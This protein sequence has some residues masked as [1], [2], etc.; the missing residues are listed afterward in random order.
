MTSDYN[1]CKC[2]PRAWIVFPIEL[3]RPRP[4]FLRQP[5]AN[6]NFTAMHHLVLAL[7]I[8]P[9]HL[10][11]LEDGDSDYHSSQETNNS[12]PC[13]DRPFSRRRTHHPTD[14]I[15]F[16]PSPALWGPFLRSTSC[17][18][19][20]FSLCALIHYFPSCTFFKLW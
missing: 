9:H 10:R 7:A 3:K 14:F 12:S 6:I 17:F 13:S 15:S 8:A 16:A 18:L 19:W 4:R 20:Y 1:L 5:P 2:H 11:A